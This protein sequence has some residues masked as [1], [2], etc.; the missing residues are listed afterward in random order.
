M[1][2]NSPLSLPIE[3]LDDIFDIVDSTTD[4]LSFALVSKALF[5][6]VVPSHLHFRYIRCRF[7]RPALWRA[8]AAEPKMASRCHKLKLT[9][10]DDGDNPR[11]PP[12]LNFEGDMTSLCNKRK[13]VWR[14]QADIERGPE[15][16]PDFDEPEIDDCFMALS[17]A[18]EKM[19]RLR[20]FVWEGCSQPS[21][22]IYNALFTSC[23]LL[24][25][26]DLWMGAE[27]VDFQQTETITTL[28]N[29]PFRRLS[30]LTQVAFT[31]HADIGKAALGAH[32][33]L[34]SAMLLACV[35]LEDLYIDIKWLASDEEE[36]VPEIQTLFLTARWPRLRR[37]SIEGF[38]L[39]DA[40]RNH[41]R[42]EQIY[43]RNHKQNEAGQDIDFR[44]LS[45]LKSLDLDFFPILINDEVLQGL[46]YLGLTNVNSDFQRL[47]NTLRLASN[48]TSL[49]LK[50]IAF[51]PYLVTF[52]AECAPRLERL[53]I[54]WLFLSERS[55]L[56]RANISVWRDVIERLPWYH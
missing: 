13:T 30:N 33:Q 6:V 23:P 34:L 51:I 9:R 38:C 50:F 1:N 44:S 45:T 18:I 36:L 5:D 2:Q 20:S 35:A 17:A 12:H 42:L 46:T 28:A 53:G 37:L 31:D 40:L 8:I 32:I 55:E 4:L 15:K 16:D 14:S 49:S 11:V 21:S 27:E 48:L 39:S 7:H 47:K 22:A 3:I 24:A 54:R 29:A 56:M 10:R 43:I 25:H 26:V 19:H 52:I 41:P